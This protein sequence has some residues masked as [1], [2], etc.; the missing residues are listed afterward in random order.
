MQTANS[1]ATLAQTFLPVKS[2]AITHLTPSRAL[3]IHHKVSLSRRNKI[4]VSY[5]KCQCKAY[6][7]SS[8]YRVLSPQLLLKK[9]EYIRDCLVYCLGLTIAQ[10]EVT[11]RLLRLWAYYGHVYPKESQITS[12][13]GCSKATYWRT[14]RVL[15]ELGLITVVNRYVIRPHAQISNLYRFDKLL[16]LI[17]RYLAE[18]G[19]RFYEKWLKSVLTMPGSYFWPLAFAA[20]RKADF[21]GRLIFPSSSPKGLGR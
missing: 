10:R 16:I 13:P 15:N 7:V 9:F 12:E 19:H 3:V 21:E 14:I 4:I 20:A 5:S 6:G 17:A 1:P 8:S 2:T 18:H 11:L